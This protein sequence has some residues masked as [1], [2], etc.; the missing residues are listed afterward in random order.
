MASL[1]GRDRV[2]VSLFAR[3]NAGWGRVRVGA[4]S[5]RGGLAAAAWGVEQVVQQLDEIRRA[6]ALGFRSVLIADLGVLQLFAAM[7]AAGELPADMQAKVSVMLPAANAASARVLQELGA[8]TI[9][10]PVDLTLGQLAA[11]RA[12]IDIP[13]DVY[14][15]SPDNLGGIVRLHEIAEIVRVAAPVHVKFGLR[16]APDLYPSGHAPRGDRRG[17]VARARATGAHRARADGARRGQY[18]TSEL[19]AAGARR[20][21]RGLTTGWVF[22]ERFLWH[23]GGG[24]P[25][26]RA[27]PAAGSS[28]GSPTSSRAS[29]PGCAR[30]STCRACARS[31]PPS[32]RGGHA[33]GAA[34][35]AHGGLARAAR[36]D[37]AGGRGSRRRE[38]AGRPRQRG[39]RVARRGRGDRS[40]RRG[41]RRPRR[42]RLRA[43]C[44]PG[45]PRRG[46]GGR[47]L[48]PASTT[49]RWQRPRPGDARVSAWSSTGTSTTA[50]GRRTR[51]R[52]PVRAPRSRST[53]TGSSRPHSRRGSTRRRPG[54]TINVPLPPGCGEGAYLACDGARS[55][56]PCCHTLR[57][58]AH[59]SSPAATTRAALDPLGRMM[60]N[61]P[62]LPPLHPRGPDAGR[63]ALR[64]PRRSSCHG[65]GYSEPLRPVLR[66]RG[67]R[68]ADRIRTA[69]EDPYFPPERELA[70]DDLQDHQRRAVDAAAAA[71]LA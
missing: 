30:C 24:P 42:Q 52:R 11:I 35:V 17:P 12:A 43:A 40:G 53:R 67:A 29:P 51:S 58:R 18:S 7:R 23:D 2:E 13:L 4:R 28:P 45:P 32:P 50:T 39:D 15:E 20:P 61:R 49:S 70:Y 14:V 60:L 9:N 1:A 3:P 37:G 33:R 62:Q 71:A 25:P 69:V 54:G 57:A 8:S 48:L 21:R 64:R 56:C 38:R 55:S 47:G 65:G 31:C 41:A 22:E 19:G 66:S 46:R 63:A 5:R 16:N 59:P 26:A 68:G 34:P 44:A 6:A 27:S 10:V 36:S